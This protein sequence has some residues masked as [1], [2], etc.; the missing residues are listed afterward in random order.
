MGNPKA[1]HYIVQDKC[2][3]CGT[4]VTVCRFD[5]VQAS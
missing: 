4:C 5:A 1:P 3:G 2:I